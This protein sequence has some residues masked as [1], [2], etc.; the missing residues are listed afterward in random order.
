M[1]SG[2]VYRVIGNKKLYLEW[3]SWGLDFYR[4]ASVVEK[5]NNLTN[6]ELNDWYLKTTKYIERKRVL[7]P[8]SAVVDLL[9]LRDET[10][11]FIKENNKR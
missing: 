7:F 6:V 4:C 1:K 5:D 11:K 9:S 10:V 3:L 2:K 8:E